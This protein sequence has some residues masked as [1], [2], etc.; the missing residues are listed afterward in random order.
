LMEPWVKKLLPGITNQNLQ[1]IDASQGNKLA[2]LVRPQEGHETWEHL[3][4]DPHIWLDFSIDMKIVDAIAEA[5]GERDSERRDVYRANAEKY[6]AKLSA[7]DESYRAG[8]KDCASRTIF[9][10]G[11][12]AFGYLARRYDLKTASPYVGFSPNAE[13]SARAVAD[14]VTKMKSTAVNH[15]YYE[16]LVTPKVANVL[17]D[18]TGAKAM[19]LHAAHNLS[20][21]E[22]AQ[23][24]TFLSIMEE[25]LKK[26][27]EGLQCQ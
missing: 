25:N 20:A 11:H 14:L 13:P 8:L 19:L 5:L 23:G 16:E 17:A 21:D 4:R 10:G 2:S 24:V 6:K 9:S 15:V 27:R 18:E 1:I 26:L 12:F 3:G 7:L 22:F